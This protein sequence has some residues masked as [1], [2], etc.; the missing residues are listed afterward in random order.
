MAEMSGRG[1]GVADVVGEER[2][3]VLY[4]RVPGAAKRKHARLVV[5]RAIGTGAG[6][7]DQWTWRA[8]A[9]LIPAAKMR[10]EPGPAQTSLQERA[11]PDKMHQNHK[12]P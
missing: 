10:T 4:N 3:C 9:W 1:T 8:I 12:M 5:W 7:G 11:P 2:A 6:H